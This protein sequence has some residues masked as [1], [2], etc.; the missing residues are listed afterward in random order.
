MIRYMQLVSMSC[1]TIITLSG[2][3]RCGAAE[4]GYKF[5]GLVISSTG[6]VF[7]KTLPRFTSVSGKFLY[8]NESA[9]T[10]SPSD[11]LGGQCAGYEQ[12]IANGFSATFTSA[13]TSLSLRA[14]DYDVVINNDFMDPA[15]GNATEDGF[16]VRWYGNLDP[17]LTGPLY[18][19]GAPHST[20]RF[21]VTMNGSSDAFTDDSIPM[22]L[23]LPKFPSSG[24]LGTL[25]DMNSG[26]TQV[27]FSISSVTQFPIYPGDYNLDGAVDVS[28]FN[29]W[30]SSFGSTTQLDA[31]GNHNQIIDAAD[32]TI[33]R[34]NVAAGTA[35]QSDHAVPEPTSLVLALSLAG[36]PLRWR[37]F[38]PFVQ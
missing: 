38:L 7:G 35:A 18:V 12:K 10:E 36:A 5:S 37:R 15:Q 17:P 6:P 30:A 16:V 14:D 3:P 9:P 23:P 11:C 19:D 32:Y 8:D 28:D 13:S 31:D 26:N 2:L 22:S 1:C 33:W 27:L 21:S 24:R 4:V 25:S 29:L 34:D 20:G